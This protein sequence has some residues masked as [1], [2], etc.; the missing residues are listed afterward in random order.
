MFKFCRHQNRPNHRKLLQ[1][2]WFPNG[3]TT[4]DFRERN[5][6]YVNFASHEKD[7]LLRQMNDFKL[8]Q[9]KSPQNSIFARGREESR[10]V[11]DSSVRD[12]RINP[13]GSYKQLPMDTEQ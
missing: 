11:S 5:T 4:S 9:T 6:R 8:K 7:R 12:S 3:G 1:L 10:D 13:A 2:S